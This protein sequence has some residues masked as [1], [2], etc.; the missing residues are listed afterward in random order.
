MA[1]GGNRF[2]VLTPKEIASVLNRLG[3]HPNVTPELID[4]P[5]S[6]QALAYFQEL[7]DFSYDLDPSQ[8]KTHLPV[9]LR[10]LGFQHAE[11]YEE[12]VDS[13]TIFKLTRQLAAINSIDDF[14]FKDIWEPQSKRFRMLL[15]AII[16]CC[17][18][19]E[20]KLSVIDSLKEELQ[21]SDSKRLQLVERV[22]DFE[23]QVQAAQEQH[24]RELHI[25]REAEAQVQKCTAEVEKL[26]RQKASA[27][28]VATSAEA[29]LAEKKEQRRQQDAETERLRA[30]VAELREQVAES[31]EGIEQEIAE[32]AGAIRE[33]RAALEDLTQEKRSR[34]QRDHVLSKLADQ[35][36]LLHETLLRLKDAAK[37]STAVKEKRTNL[38]QELES[39][40]QQNE[41]RSAE[42]SDLQ[43]R[44]RQLSAEQERAKAAHEQQVQELAARRQ[45]AFEQHQQLQAKRNEE[46]KQQ[47]LLQ[48][49]RMELEMEVAAA[50]RAFDAELAELQEKQTEIQNKTEEYVQQVE[51]LCQ[52]PAGRWGAGAMTSPPPKSGSSQQRSSTGVRSLAARLIACSPSPARNIST[53]PLGFLS[54]GRE[55]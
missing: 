4:K 45:E 6:E 48:M 35:I 24:S 53:N 5:T 31:P 29:G 37:A 13:V 12:A 21:E 42:E 14:T 47:H 33:H 30:Q 10:N 2:K 18:Y 28:R 46:Q 39:L 54:P 55:G 23:R 16:N 11:I 7:A 8:V 20:N 51:L 26:Q 19:K 34:H 50:Q 38:G 41:A 25:M 32:Q 22:N 27:E 36:E 40:K 43:D 52:E 49:Q 44:V 15:S 9:L 17:R 3:V 1:S